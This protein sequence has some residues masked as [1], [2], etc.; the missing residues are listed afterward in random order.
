[1]AGGGA[2][3][4]HDLSDI[5][6][7]SKGYIESVSF[8]ISSETA[9]VK[10]KDGK[11]KA[12]AFYGHKREAT[13]TYITKGSVPKINDTMDFGGKQYYVTSVEEIGSNSDWIKFSV[14]ATHYGKDSSIAPE[15]NP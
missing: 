7:E 9:D 14:K 1:M 13:A 10:D 2:G 8:N 5:A 11:V 3:L 6:D 15:A 4:K 12:K